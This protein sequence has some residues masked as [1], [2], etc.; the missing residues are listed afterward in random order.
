MMPAAGRLALLALA[1]EGVLGG[2]NTDACAHGACLNGFITIEGPA[3]NC[4]YA[5]GKKMPLTEADCEKAATFLGRTLVPIWPDSATRYAQLPKCGAQSTDTTTVFWNAPG[6]ELSGA[7]GVFRAICVM[8]NTPW[9]PNPPPS[10]PSP[11]STPP[12]LPPWTAPIPPPK[13]P[14]PP[15]PS[16]SPEPASP[17]PTPPPPDLNVGVVV[18][19]GLGGAVVIG[20]VAT[21]IAVK[22]KAKAKAKP[23]TAVPSTGVTA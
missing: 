17:P 19:A 11:P 18:A 21:V 1:V 16:P 13:P 3:A 15:P 7:Q 2:H 23:S 14:S 12:M 8:E 20:T 4:Y 5:T 9:P 22:V 6:A 10:P